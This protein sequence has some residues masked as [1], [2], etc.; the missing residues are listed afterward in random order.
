[1]AKAFDGIASE[2]DQLSQRVEELE[3]RVSTLETQPEHKTAAPHVSGSAAQPGSQPSETWRR[4][5]APNAPA[6]A[7]PVFGKAV[8]GIAG[9]YLLRAVAELGT[10]SKLPLLMVAIV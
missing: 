5:P 2:I 7:L 9:A 4:F 3:R 1:M 10:V 6:G 8:V